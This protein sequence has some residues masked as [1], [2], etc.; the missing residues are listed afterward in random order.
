MGIVFIDPTCCK[1][2]LKNGYHIKT[3][4]CF[5]AFRIHN[6]LGD[7]YQHRDQE[8]FIQVVH[9]LASFSDHNDEINY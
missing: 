6:D 9:R 7:H 3:V 8:A 4:D 1:I 2:S 5:G